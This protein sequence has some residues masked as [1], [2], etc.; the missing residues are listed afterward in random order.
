MVNSPNSSPEKGQAPTLGELRGEIDR[1][2]RVMHALLIEASGFIGRLIK[3]KKSMETASA[4]RPARQAP[5]TRRS[6]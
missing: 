6:T 3:V 2:D 1:I 4:F 5:M